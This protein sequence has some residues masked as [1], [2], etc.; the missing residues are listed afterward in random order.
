MDIIKNISVPTGN[1]LIVNGSTG[2]LECLSL[3]DYGKQA[4]VKA[5]F[6][7]LNRDIAG[8]QMGNVCLCKRSGW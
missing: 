2:K 1:I 3:G 4:N 6:M 8:V 5:Q 7:G